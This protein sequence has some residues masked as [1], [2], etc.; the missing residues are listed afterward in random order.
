[1]SKVILFLCLLT[2]WFRA[3]PPLV[4][5]IDGLIITLP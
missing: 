4:V 1:M 5:N 3:I 2:C